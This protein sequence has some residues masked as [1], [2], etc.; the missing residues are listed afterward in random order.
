MNN[1]RRNEAFNKMDIRKQKMIEILFNSINGK[2]LKDA[3]P[4]LVNWKTKLKDEG[5]TFTKEEN[6]ILMDIFI[7]E[8]SPAQ[9]RQFEMLKPLLHNSH[10]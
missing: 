8:L 2:E 9:R 5:I 6:D 4:I 3:L 7:S 1:W 10:K